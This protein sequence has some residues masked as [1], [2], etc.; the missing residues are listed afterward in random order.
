MLRQNLGQL[1]QQLADSGLSTGRFDVSGGS[2]GGG[3]ANGQEHM[4]SPEVAHDDTEGSTDDVAT[5]A[6]AS[7][8]P[9]DGQIDMRL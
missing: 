6:A 9:T 3:A 5:G 7:T 2:D 4:G 8:S 1:R